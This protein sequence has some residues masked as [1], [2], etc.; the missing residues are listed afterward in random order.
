MLPSVSR[1]IAESE[2][3]KEE[4]LA[5]VLKALKDAVYASVTQREIEAA[6]VR[7]CR[8]R[9]DR[10]LKKIDLSGAPTVAD[11][12]K[13]YATQT[14]SLDIDT[15][16]KTASGRIVEAIKADNLP[17]LLANYDNKGLMALASKHLKRSKVD[18][19]TSWLTRVLRNASVPDLL[20]AI[21]KELPKLR[22]GG[23]WHPIDWSPILTAID[24]TGIP[25]E[26]VGAS[27]VVE[28]NSGA[29][30]S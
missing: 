14:R 27:E 15:I 30:N 8:R 1:A 22:L 21:Q 17:K 29:R 26:C 9:I 16:A 20:A 7:Y 18:A 10:V 11:I 5:S 25:K 28:T 23:G 12:D 3:Y 13:E 19:F 24:R 4:E 2:G 6:A